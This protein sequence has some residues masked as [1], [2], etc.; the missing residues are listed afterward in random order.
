[1]TRDT[2]DAIIIDPES[3]PKVLELYLEISQYPL[4]APVIRDR[5][6]SE[7]FRRGVISPADLEQEITNKALMSQRREGL[8]DPFAQE[9]EA[10]WQRRLDHYRDNLTDFYFAHNLPHSHFEDIVRDVLARRLPPDH[11]LLTFN[12]ELAP[13]SVLFHRGEIYESLPHAERERFRH[14]LREICVVLIKGLLNDQLGYVGIAKDL[15]TIADLKQI[16]DRRI[17]RG[18]IGGKAA[19]MM[20]AWKILQLAAQ[21][22]EAG[23][24]LASQVTIPESYFLGADVFYEFIALNHL[25]YLNDQKYKPRDEIEAEYERVRK[26]FIGGHF[27]EGVVQ[28][29]R[30]KLTNIGNRPIIVRS[31]SLLEDNLGTSFAGKYDSFFLPNQA[32]LEK[33]LEALLLAISRIYA[34][35]FSPSALFYRQQMGLLDYDERMAILLQEV[36]GE[37]HGN[38]F[39]PTLAGVAFSHNPFRWTPKIQHDEGFVRLVFGLGTR[40]VERVANDYPRMVALGHPDLRPETGAAEIRRYSQRYVDVIDL[41]QNDLATMPLRDVLTMDF[42]SARQLVSVD[43]G[44]YLQQPVAYDPTVSPDHL[45]PTFENLLTRTHF[46]SLIRSILDELST[47]FGVDVDVE[48]TA[49]VTPGYPRPEFHV[50]ILQCRPQASRE[51]S[52]KVVMPTTVAEADVLF[53]AHRLVPEG[54]LERIRHIVYVD[55][56]AYMRTPDEPTRLQVARVVGRL[57]EVLAPK[58]FLLM[59]PGRWGTNNPDLGV[60]VTYADIYKTAMLVEIGLSEGGTAP[61]AS[62]GTHFF[63]DLVEARIYPLAVFPNE[64]STQFNWEFF[65]GAQNRLADVLPGFAAFTQYVRVIDVPASTGGRFVEVVMDAEAGEAMAYLRE[66]R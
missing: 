10:D 42:P 20:L 19:G 39:F 23:Q 64:G 22:G 51:A 58:S 31:S 66:Y 61:E 60:K 55:P 62:Y 48:F 49:S 1:M 59:G 13:W 16:R 50:T 27:P 18:K 53:T 25:H 8:T 47:G 52:G 32:T 26:A 30:R 29:L 28:E 6:R 36:Q 63:Q 5:M 3:M 34:S 15:F 7:L 45:V 57:N 38:Y 17:G 40:A 2:Q 21:K 65:E 41:A 12:P 54:H 9:S 33:N 24:W 11:I 43:R 35:V 14:H 4:L 44:D 46:V 56:R 37:R